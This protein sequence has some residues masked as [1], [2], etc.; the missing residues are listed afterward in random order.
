MDIQLNGKFYSRL[1][2]CTVGMG[3]RDTGKIL[4]GPTL[5]LLA[6]RNKNVIFELVYKLL[7]IIIIIFNWKF[8]I[9]N[10]ARW[11]VLIPPPPRLSMNTI[12]TAKTVASVIVKSEISSDCDRSTI[13]HHEY[14][15]VAGWALD[16]RLLHANPGTIFY[17]F[18]PTNSQ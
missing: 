12:A 6:C 11:R 14:R 8:Y 2:K 10:G 18:P 13:V 3:R 9:L 15:Y 5:V 4:G 7:R 17:S 1:Q 16:G